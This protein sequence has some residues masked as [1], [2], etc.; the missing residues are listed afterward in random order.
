M[1]TIVDEVPAHT[2]VREALLD[3]SFGPDRHLKTS[4]RLREG[5]LP[6]FAYSAL[7]ENGT[8]VGTVRLWAVR[9]EDGTDCLLL[10]PLAVDPALRGQKVG[11][12]LMR[13]ALNQAAVFGHRSVILVGDPNYYVRFGFRGG[14]LANLDL[15]GPVDRHRFLALD[16]R[17]GASAALCGVLQAAGEMAQTGLATDQDRFSQI[18]DRL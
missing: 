13:H 16:L 9:D 12:R 8:L 3:L 5:R 17:A 10:G 1:V 15:P 18:G 6:V 4:E 7:D 14:L 11:D 2:G